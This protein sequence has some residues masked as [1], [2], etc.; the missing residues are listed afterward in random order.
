MQR[1][2][3]DLAACVCKKC[4][5]SVQ[6]HPAPQRATEESTLDVDLEFAVTDLTGKS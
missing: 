2:W 5:D 6:P 4:R 3:T 1:M